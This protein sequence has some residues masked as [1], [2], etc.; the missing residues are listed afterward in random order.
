M[1]KKEFVMIKRLKNIKISK[2]F[3]MKYPRTLKLISK[4]EY[5]LRNNKFEQP[6]VINKDNVLVDGYTSYI[7]AQMLNKKWVRVKRV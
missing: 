4:M 6:I 3:K 2:E 5:Y 7:I 1:I